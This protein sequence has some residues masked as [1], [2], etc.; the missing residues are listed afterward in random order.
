MSSPNSVGRFSGIPHWRWGI[1]GLREL[2]HDS[3]RAIHFDEIAIVPQFG[4]MFDSGNARQSVFS[5][6][7]SAVLEEP[8]DGAIL[9]Q[10]R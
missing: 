8:S 9:F 3:R 7:Q 6:N 4:G 10:E 5:R 2:P 1:F